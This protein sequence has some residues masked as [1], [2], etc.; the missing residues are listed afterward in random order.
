VR[1]LSTQMRLP[2]LRLAW[3]ALAL[4]IPARWGWRSLPATL[5]LLVPVAVEVVALSLI[6]QE[7]R[8]LVWLTAPSAA[9]VPVACARIFERVPR[10]PVAVRAG[11]GGLLALVLGA[12]AVPVPRVTPV[13]PDPRLQL[14]TWARM[15]LRASDVLVDCGRPA[16]PA[17]ARAERLA[18]SAP[19]RA[20]SIA[21]AASRWAPVVVGLAVT[22]GLVVRRHG[23][24]RAGPVT[25]S[26][27]E[28]NYRV[29]RVR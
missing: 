8:Y 11:A 1:T 19:D 21:A 4:L 10:L 23:A 29:W 6:A 12:R 9:L 5:L 2:D 25:S 18:V 26:A 22:V 16:A 13:P 28:S 15:S 24:G 7:Q 3:L 20:K 14:A 17:G 27:G